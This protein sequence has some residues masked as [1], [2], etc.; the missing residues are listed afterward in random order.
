M[1][2]VPSVR[3]VLVAIG[4]SLFLFSC[5]SAPPPGES[6]GSPEGET[7]GREARKEPGTPAGDPR[8]SETGEE[9]PFQE[10]LM[11]NKHGTVYTDIDRYDVRNIRFNTGHGFGG[12]DA[13]VGYYKNTRFEIKKR[14]IDKLTVIGKV[15]RSEILSESHRYDMIEDKDVDYIFRTDLKKTDGERIEF[16]VRINQISGELQ[17]GGAFDLRGDELKALRKI[18]FF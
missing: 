2:T 15:S 16:I 10:T 8:G 11:V 3:T 7:P 9:D 13:L 4:L 5:A 6:N 14:F 18:V 1:P 17:E 12:G